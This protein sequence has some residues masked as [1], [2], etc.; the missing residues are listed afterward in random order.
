MKPLETPHQSETAR[1]P[2]LERLLARRDIWRGRN[3]DGDGEPTGFAA[4]DDHLAAGGWPHGALTELLPERAGVGELRLLMPVLARLSQGP[5]WVAWIDPPYVPHA[6][7][8]YAS[9]VDLAH[10]LV[11]HPRPG[12][13]RAGEPSR[14]RPNESLWA[15]EQALASG[16]CSAVLAWP[17]ALTPK[18]MRRLQLAAERGGTLGF[19]FR[20]PREADNQVTHAALRLALSPSRGGLRIDTLRQRGGRSDDGIHL[21]AAELFHPGTQRTPDPALPFGTG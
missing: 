13:Q 12:E 8:L 11:V 15:L 2:A 16:T 21:S 17:G 5:R 10:T 4:L 9:G 19:L 18:A 3:T 1:D 7:G 6:A 14:K 20:G